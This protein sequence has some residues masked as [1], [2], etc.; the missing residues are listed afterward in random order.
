MTG[1]PEIKPDAIR[2]PFIADSSIDA[3]EC[4]RRTNVTPVIYQDCF[5]RRQKS[6]YW[7]NVLE[8]PPVAGEKGQNQVR[9]AFR[10]R[11]SCFIALSRLDD[12]GART[13]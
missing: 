11:I 1:N 12:K 7:L 8:I 2:T 5:A 4:R 10:S 13:A 6:V 9:V 3:G